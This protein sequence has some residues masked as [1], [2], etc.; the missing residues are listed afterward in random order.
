LLLCLSLLFLN[1]GKSFPIRLELRPCRMETSD[2]SRVSWAGDE[3]TD[4]CVVC[5]R[6][7]NSP[8]RV[9]DICEGFTGGGSEAEA[10]EEPPKQVSNFHQAG[11]G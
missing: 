9:W 5:R 10:E 7:S 2:C 11:L 3:H 4:E 6:G 8:D 1:G